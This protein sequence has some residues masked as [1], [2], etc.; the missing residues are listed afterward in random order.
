MNLITGSRVDM[1]S[2]QQKTAHIE[3]RHSG[4]ISCVKPSC[5]QVDVFMKQADELCQQR[6]QRFTALRKQVLSLICQSEQPLGAYAL[7]DLMKASG[8]S[9]APPTVYRALDFLQEQGFVH[10]LASNN[11]YLACAHPQHRHEAVFLVCKHCG[12]TQELH[13]DGVFH[14]LEDRA[15]KAGFKVEHA[16]VEVT[17]LCARCQAEGVN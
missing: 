17:G 15:S 16:S 3:C 9:A 4:G 10:R 12:F 2:Q 11:T 14:A 8:R 1:A 6:Q 5:K 7:L 13:T